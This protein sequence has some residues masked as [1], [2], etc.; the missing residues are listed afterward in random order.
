MRQIPEVETWALYRSMPS[1]HHGDVKT[2]GAN[3]DVRREHI[4]R[5]YRLVSRCSGRHVRMTSRRVDA[6]ASFDDVYGMSH[7]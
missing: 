4:I 5:H 7:D 3:G 1:R 6:R 2:N